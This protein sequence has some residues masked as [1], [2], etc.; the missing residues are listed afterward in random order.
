MISSHACSATPAPLQ[1][2]ID[3]PARPF[4]GMPI[5]VLAERVGFEPTVP[6]GY[7]GFRDRPVRPLQHLSDLFYF[8][9]KVWKN[10][11]KT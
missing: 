11:R 2:F 8:F 9:R 7:T 4:W 5:F 6:R 3:F 10:V 1:R